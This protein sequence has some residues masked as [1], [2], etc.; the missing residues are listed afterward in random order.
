MI[1]TLT[2]FLNFIAFVE[3]CHISPYERS[4]NSDSFRISVYDQE[5]NMFRPLVEC[6]ITE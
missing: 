5:Y 4:A 3:R 2:I 6:D 1:I